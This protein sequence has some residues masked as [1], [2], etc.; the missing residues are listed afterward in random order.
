MLHRGII[1]A[2]KKWLDGFWPRKELTEFKD[3]DGWR[4]YYIGIIR[5]IALIA[6]PIGFAFSIPNFVAQGNYG[7]IAFEVGVIILIALMSRIR[8]TTLSIKIFFIMFYGLMLTFIITLG[9]LYARAGWVVMCVVGAAF[10]FGVRAAIITTS[11]NAVLLMLLYWQVGPHLRAWAS[12][13]SEHFA[14]WIMFVVNISLVSLFASLPVGLL[15]NQMN[16]L[17]INERDLHMQLAS[18]SEVLQSINTALRNEIAERQKTEEEK[19][20][21]QTDL[22]QAQKMEAVGTLAGGI[23][24]DFNNILSAIIGYSE[25]VLNDTAVSEKTR[26][27]IIEI[28]NSGERAKAL[29]NQIL[30]FSRKAE[31]R[32]A[33]LELKEAIS[34]ALKMMRSL[35]PANITIEQNYAASGLVLSSSTY[36]HQIIMNLCSNAI[37]AMEN[38]GGVLEVFLTRE[39]ID[40]QSAAG[41]LRLP[42]GSYLKMTISDTGQGMIPEVAARVFEPYFTTKETGRGTGLGLSV[43]HGIVKSHGGAIACRSTAGIGTSFEIYFPEMEDRRKQEDSRQ[44]EAMP[45]GT[46]TILYVD[47]EPMLCDIASEMLES[48]GYQVVGKTS[49]VE[50]YDL[51]IVEP[52]RFAAVITDMSMPQLTGDKLAQKILALRPDTPIIVCTG[53][54]EHVSGED[55]ARLGVREFLMK[56]YKM[57]QLAYAV[58]RVIDGNSFAQKH[59]PQHV[60]D[61]FRE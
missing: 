28:L 33:P 59:K 18:E 3:L 19:K 36:I 50:A 13:Y 32:I 23:A 10:L 6:L 2:G 25:L 37:H 40:A 26:Q 46:E 44:E 58:R 43:V 12:V 45:T 41:E 42:A 4:I 5:S 54:S 17:L 7:L 49:S 14:T 29:V 34:E 31:I 53:Y 20:H 52:Q 27:K 21:L 38:D 51:F 30:A 11:I 1:R 48:L 9:P 16:R 35:I 47:D 55:A 60:K 24:H 56:P 61:I 22:A 15:L 8:Y 57:P 39:Q